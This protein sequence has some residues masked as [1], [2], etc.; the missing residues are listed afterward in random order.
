MTNI[1]QIGSRSVGQVFEAQEAFN[2]LNE[3]IILCENRRFK[4]NPPIE[5]TG[6][7][8]G[9]LTLNEE[10]EIVVRFID[11][12]EQLTKQEYLRKYLIVDDNQSDPI[13]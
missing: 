3:Q 2:L 8:V 11:S 6:V 9:V 10:I 4:A 5:M 13:R 7:I 12:L 1:D